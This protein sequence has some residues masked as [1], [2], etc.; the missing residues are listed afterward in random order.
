MSQLYI[1]N[2]NLGDQSRRPLRQAS[3]TVEISDPFADANLEC[4]ENQVSHASK[5]KSIAS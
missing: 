4:A 5:L 2:I 3:R 1:A